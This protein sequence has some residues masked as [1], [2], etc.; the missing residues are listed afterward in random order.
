M[1]HKNFSLS[2]L[3]LALFSLYPNLCAANG[4][5][6]LHQSATG[7]STAYATNGTGA[8]DISAMFP[9]PA[10]LI[11]FDGTRASAGFVLDLPKSRLY[12][13]TATTHYRVEIYMPT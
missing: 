3:A 7:M 13:A 10:S 2:T 8:K 4:Y 6:F 12:N 11:R 5:H 9:N 1:H